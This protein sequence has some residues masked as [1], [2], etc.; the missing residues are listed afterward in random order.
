[1][2]FNSAIS[3]VISSSNRNTNERLHQIFREVEFQQMM[4]RDII[5]GLKGQTKEARDEAKSERARCERY[6]EER[7]ELK[8]ALARAEAAAMEARRRQQQQA[9]VQK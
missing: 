3:S 8:A 6:M 2:A 7:E 9:N 4:F 5:K 1:M